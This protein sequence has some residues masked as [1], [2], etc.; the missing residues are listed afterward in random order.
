MDFP[1]EAFDEKLVTING[2]PVDQDGYDDAYSDWGA[3]NDEE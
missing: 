3:E 2:I 1:P